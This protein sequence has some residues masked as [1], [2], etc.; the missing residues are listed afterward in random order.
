M[1]NLKQSLDSAKTTFATV[2]QKENE[3][4]DNYLKLGG[5]WAGQLKSATGTGKMGDLSR[6]LGGALEKLPAMK[7][8]AGL[9]RAMA[10]GMDSLQAWAASN[11]KKAAMLNA[12]AGLSGAALGGMA[13][14]ALGGGPSA[15]QQ[16]DQ[17]ATQQPVQTAQNTIPSKSGSPE[18]QGFQSGM[19][20]NG[21]E[22]NWQNK[23]FQVSPEGKTSQTQSGTFT[24][25]SPARPDTS[26]GGRAANFFA[27]QARKAALRQKGTPKEIQSSSATVED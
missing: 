11:P 27:R 2:N 3:R 13:G 19:V 5:G 4:L 15:P 25:D 14:G 6:W 26:V 24:P 10:K 22:P 16:Q 18:I 17:N 20:D 21:A 9:R 8:D 12:A 1:A 23:D 7:Q